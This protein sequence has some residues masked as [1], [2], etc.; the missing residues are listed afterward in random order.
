MIDFD[1]ETRATIG[2]TINEVVRSCKYLPV[3]E[4]ATLVA[5]EI[6]GK[7][8]KIIKEKYKI[9]AYLHTPPKGLPNLTIYVE[10]VV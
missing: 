9:L 10:P 1:A 7:L 4:T 2:K 8:R 6:D 3:P 5:E